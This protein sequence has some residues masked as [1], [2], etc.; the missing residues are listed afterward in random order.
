MST[1]LKPNAAPLCVASSQHTHTHT[2][3][4]RRQTNYRE[5]TMRTLTQTIYFRRKRYWQSLAHCTLHPIQKTTGW[6]NF[7][8]LQQ[9]VV[10]KNGRWRHSWACESHNG[11]Q[12]RLRGC[13]EY[14]RHTF[15]SMSLK[16][17]NNKYKLEH[18]LEQKV[19][20]YNIFVLLNNTFIT[21]FQEQSINFRTEITPCH[22]YL[23]TTKV[24]CSTPVSDL[25]IYTLLL[26]SFLR[27]LRLSMVSPHKSQ[28]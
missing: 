16:I 21:S 9:H 19:K 23:T 6:L 4:K 27:I 26:H 7:V 2:Q 3:I 28:E 11:R 5:T 14:W 10:F 12:P 24:S 17:I 22:W 15:N 18:Y 13:T 8:Q 20:L 1:E 25:N